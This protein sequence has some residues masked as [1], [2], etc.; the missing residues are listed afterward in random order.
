MSFNRTTEGLVTSLQNLNK[1]YY[2][3]R[4]STVTFASVVSGLNYDL[5]YGAPNANVTNSSF[6]SNEEG[7]M[8]F[9]IGI[10]KIG[11]QARVAR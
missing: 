4:E 11:L 1:D 3:Y 8:L 6:I 9:M 2:D 7:Y 10:D 5:T